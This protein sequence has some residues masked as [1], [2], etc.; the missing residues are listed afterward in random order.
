MSQP[1]CHIE[2]LGH[3]HYFAS[4][5]VSDLCCEL[6]KRGGDVGEEGDEF[7]ESVS[8]DYL[9]SGFFHFYPEVFHGIRW[10]S[11]NAGP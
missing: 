5:E 3:L 6:L 4:L 7:R 11:K 1:V 9:S 10:I 2:G 8:L